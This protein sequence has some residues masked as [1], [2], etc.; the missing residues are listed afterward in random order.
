M[1]STKEY[2]YAAVDWCC[3]TADCWNENC[4]RV[5]ETGYQAAASLLESARRMCRREPLPS[6]PLVCVAIVLATGCA[7][8]PCAGISERVWWLAATGSLA[9]WILLACD[10]RILLKDRSSSTSGVAACAAGNLAVIPLTVAI[11]CGGAGWSVVRYD[12]FGADELAWSLTESPVPIAIQGTVVESPRL[13]TP[14]SPELLRGIVLGPSSECI[15]A[16]QAV[17][18]GSRWRGASGR[19]VVILDGPPPSLTAGSRVRVFGRGLRPSP[20]LNPGEFDFRERARSLRC[21]SIVRSPGM[22]CIEILSPPPLLSLTAMIDRVRTNGIAVLRKHVSPERAP[23]AA[24]LLLGSRE[25]LPSEESREF[26]VTGTIHILSISGLHVGILAL[27]LLKVLRT[28]AVPH[29]WSLVSVALC[30]GLYMLLVRAETPVV[31]ATLLVWLSCLAALVGRRSLALNALAVAAILVLLWHPPEIF[32]IGTQLS[33]VST[34]VLIAA[35]AAL[36]SQRASGDPIDR[37]IQRSRPPLHRWA[38]RYAR[39]VLDVFLVGAAIWAVTAPVVAAWFHVVSPIGLVLN[40]VIAPLVAMAMGWG[41]LCLAAAPFS[42]LLA[43]LFGIA[44]DTTL[45]CIDWIVTWAASLPGAYAWVSGPPAWWVAGWY[46]LIATTLMA[47]P[48]QRLKRIATWCA[49]AGVWI[50]VGFLGVAATGILFPRPLALEAVVAAMGHG[51]GIVVRSPTNRVLV[52]DAGRLGAPAAA[53]RAMSAVLWSAGINHIDRLVISHADTDHFNAVPELLERFSVGELVVS[54]AFLDSRS[55]A[56]GEVLGRVHLLRIPIRTVHAGDSIPFDALCRVRVLHPAPEQPG[57]CERACGSRPSGSDRS[58]SDNQTSL[59]LAIESA[60]R[61]L[62]LTGDLEG[63]AMVQF[64]AADPDTCDAFIAP[65]HGSRTS[66]PPALAKATAPDWVFVSGIGGSS[67]N[68][69][70]RAYEEA[71]ADRHRITVIHTGGEGAIAMR[72]TAAETTVWQ[73]AAQTRSSNR[74]DPLLGRGWRPIR[75]LGIRPDS[76][77]SPPLAGRQFPAYNATQPLQAAGN[78]HLGTE[79]I[80]SVRPVQSHKNVARPPAGS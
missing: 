40:P 78:S 58:E 71:R 77:V 67:W 8:G 44:C 59:V 5:A 10:R 18:D 2:G 38:R 69:V 24:A 43:G 27:A 48:S 12:L 66:L 60:G 68:Q 14:P 36:P 51:C 20:A 9:L 52:Y 32:R 79:K 26:L 41:F 76:P 34:A 62:L 23:L 6:R 49:V 16:V 73:F 15:V 63:N 33:F 64:V 25:S 61:R 19:A 53:R 57:S 54:Q 46:V 31:R 50:G 21:L 72:L 56:V 75:Q 13:L 70:R 35:A 74:S 39:Q 30:T 4:Q 55:L 3:V 45:Q 22:D 37:L 28:L 65:H 42:S 29:G 1:A 11:A 7:I 17:R 47:L 80:P